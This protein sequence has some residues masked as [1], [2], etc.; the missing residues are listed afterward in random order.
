MVIVMLTQEKLKEL[1][2]YNPQTGF[3]TWVKSKGRAKAGSI[4]GCPDKDGY[5]LIGIN[6]KLYKAHRLAFIYMEG[7]EPS[8]DVDHINRVTGD[9]RWSNL[10]HA[11]RSQNNINRKCKGYYWSSGI[12][13]YC[14]LIQV[15]GNKIHLGYHESEAEAR[16]AYIDASLKY[17]GQFTS[18]T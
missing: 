11:T 14:A 7:S 15:N 18:A 4:A 1:L 13:K 9:N 12:R 10:R 17:F 3:F 6:R 8:H 16:K 5:I 2:H